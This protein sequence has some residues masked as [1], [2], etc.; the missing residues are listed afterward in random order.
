MMR[1]ASFLALRAAAIAFFL[2]T[3]AYGI[4]S[5]SPFAFDMFIRP[6]LLRWVNDFVAWHHVWYLGAYA[7][8]VASLWHDLDWRRSRSGADRIAHRLALAYAAVL[9][10]VALKL[11]A[12]PHLP[13]LWNDSRSLMTGLA[14]FVP[15]VW[16]AVIDHLSALR[17][18]SPLDDGPRAGRV[19]RV[20]VTC[21]FTAAGLW[22]V[23]L[24]HVVAR[25]A[26]GRDLVAAWI[27]TGGWT[28]A[29]TTSAFGIAFTVLALIDGC[30]AQ[31]ARPQR[32]A[33]LLTV[34]AIA[35]GLCELLRRLV[36]PAISLDAMASLAVGPVGGIALALTWSG[37]AVRRPRAD[38]RELATPLELLLAPAWSKRWTVAALA[39][40]PIVA[41]VAIARVERLDW[42]FVLQR[43]VAI[44]EWTAAF[45]LVLRLTAGVRE[46]AWSIRAAAIAPIAAMLVFAGLPRAA[47]TLAA[48]SGDQALQP[49]LVFQR[50]AAAE[51]SFALLAK[52]LVRWPGFDAGYHR[53]LQVDAAA[54][55][56]IQIPDV[57]FAPAVG[58][59][60]APSTRRPDIYLF[61]VDSL[62]RDYLSPYN[63]AVSFTPNI[64]RFA[65]DAFVFRNAFTRHGGTA[66]AIP[67]IWTGSSVVRKIL[68]PGFE[69][70]NT[71]QKLLDA[72]GYRIAI[73]D[74]TVAGRLNPSVRPTVIDAGVPSPETDLCSNL[75]GLQRH[76]AEPG[77]DAHPLFAFFAPMNVHLINTRHEGRAAASDGDYPGFYS[78]YASRLKRIDGCFGDFVSYL[79]REGRYD[80]SIIIVTSDHG[81]SLGEEG[82]WGH[83]FWL[84]PEDIRIPLLL[85]VPASLKPELT[86]DLS[87]I[88]F[89]TDIAPTLYTLL[90]HD[91]RDPGP[92]FGS[93][94]VGPR[95]RDLPSRRRESYLVTSS[96]APTYALLRRNGRS[97]Y[98]S[99][100]FERKEFAFDLSQEPIGTQVLVDNAVRRVNQRL[101]RDRVTELSAFF[102]KT[103][104]G[105]GSQ[106]LTQR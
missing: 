56:S 83:A 71:M 8:S 102:R 15:L 61:V 103:V 30:A 28:F 4:V 94:L 47:G 81:D 45:G 49:T 96:Y 101:I 73:N 9:G 1:F 39:T 16:L 75:T 3:A 18:W 87:R 91:V 20:L 60:T 65:G 68:G 5:Y 43:L 105:S 52:A 64:D 82:L 67:S 36:L 92:I 17:A 69:R 32:C 31:A 37:I 29:L 7:A 85:K 62:R 19:H 106:T 33:H 59:L 35:G 6:Q 63:P 27:L 26:D 38:E 44:A 86:T 88:A 79:K 99:D 25:Q 41:F 51:P 50:H 57:D 97:L 34:T 13:T 80:D 42:D 84:F 58:W 72:E 12:A 104:P 21:A 54:A 93:P 78:P 48:W 89:S 22:A 90:Q 98:V 74:Y 70:M 53:H 77:T 24:A 55:G 23:H 11:A 40:L 10:A 14:A 76:L 46:R 66:L 2:L 95:G 100:L